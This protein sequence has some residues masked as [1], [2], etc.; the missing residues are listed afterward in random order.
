[1]IYLLNEKLSLFHMGVQQIGLP[2]LLTSLTLESHRLQKTKG[3]I[4][5]SYLDDRYQYVQIH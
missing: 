4:V 3:E 2:H 5:H 1:M